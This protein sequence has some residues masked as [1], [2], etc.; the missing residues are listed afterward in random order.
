VTSIHGLHYAAIVVVN[1]SH[2]PSE[3]RPKGER[4]KHDTHAQPSSKR[5][6]IASSDDALPFEVTYAVDSIEPVEG[7]RNVHVSTAHAQMAML[8]PT[9]IC[10]QRLLTPLATRPIRHWRRRP[11]TMTLTPKMRRQPMT[12]T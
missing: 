4:T 1:W 8:P 3:L 2:F 5:Q 7:E 11:T 6:R 12:M 9:L 10:H